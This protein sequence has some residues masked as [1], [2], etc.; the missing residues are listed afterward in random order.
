MGRGFCPNSNL[1][2]A[3]RL[4]LAGAGTCRRHSVS[5]HVLEFSNAAGRFRRI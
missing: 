4:R 5:H 2:E 3:Q 1:R